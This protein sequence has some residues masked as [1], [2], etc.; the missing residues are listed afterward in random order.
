MNVPNALIE[1]ARRHIDYL[2]AELRRIQFL[3]D[4]SQE[5]EQRIATVTACYITIKQINADQEEIRTWLAD[6]KGREERNG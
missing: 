2:D 6:Q 1:A 4:K 5:L 3:L